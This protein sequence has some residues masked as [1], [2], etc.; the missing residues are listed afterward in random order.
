M[1]YLPDSIPDN[2][3]GYESTIFFGLDVQTETFST[4][5]L[6]THSGDFLLGEH[7]RL[8]F[9][10]ADHIDQALL[11]SADPV[12]SYEGTISTSPNAY[13]IAT[14]CEFS[15]TAERSIF[16]I[17]GGSMAEMPNLELYGCT[18]RQNG[19]APVI[20]LI[21][22]YAV[23][24]GITASENMGTEAISMT[25]SGNGT[26]IVI[27]ETS[28]LD[29]SELTITTVDTA[30]ENSSQNYSLT[31]TEC[32][33]TSSNT[34][35]ANS[36]TE[37]YLYGS[38]LTSERGVG[39]QNSGYLVLS[40]GCTVSGATYALYNSGSVISENSLNTFIL[41]SADGAYTVYSDTTNA[42]DVTVSLYGTFKAKSAAQIFSEQA[43]QETDKPTE[44]YDTD[45][46]TVLYYMVS[47]EYV[48]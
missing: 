18:V 36:G 10:S 26:G 47:R 16:V 2:S 13:F 31:L 3:L 29:A 21:G 33:I 44:E 41:T 45:Q 28:R 14:N 34:A 37:L 9:T 5:T 46:V 23:L 6:A 17:D 24:N 40:E 11:Y 7:V 32:T 38:T 42:V 30:V 27:D 39:I 22:G 48:G 15:A 12:F 35:I 20:G 1:M 4:V 19:I 8:E 43:A 25:V